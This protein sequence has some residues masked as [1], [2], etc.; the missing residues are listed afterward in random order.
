MSYLYV[1]WN[2]FSAWSARLRFH[3]LTLFCV[4]LAPPG[5]KACDAVGGAFR[6]QW[7]EGPA[8]TSFPARRQLATPPCGSF[9]SMPSAV[10]AL[11]VLQFN[12]GFL[13]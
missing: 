9:P 6:S 2:S 13:D 1:K 7:R 4:S 11:A 8:R 3:H 5:T 12:V 10:P